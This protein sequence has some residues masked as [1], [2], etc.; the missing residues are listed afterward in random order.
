MLKSTEHH[1]LTGLGGH[2]DEHRFMAD[3]LFHHQVFEDL[4]AVLFT[5]AEVKIL[6][7]EIVRLLRTHLQRLLAGVCRIH[8]L[9]AQLAQHRTHGT[10]KIREIIDDQ[11]TLLVIRQHRG[12]PGN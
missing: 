5:V 8:V 3:E 11:K 1:R 4:L 7:D 9:D 12:F 6:Q 10:A 2:H